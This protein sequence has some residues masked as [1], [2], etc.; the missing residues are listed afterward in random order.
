M[1]SRTKAIVTERS[2]DSTTKGPEWQ[3]PVGYLL[4]TFLHFVPL[5][6]T[7]SKFNCHR[8]ILS[9]PTKM[10]TFFVIRAQLEQGVWP[11]LLR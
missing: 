11:V 1:A 7:L 10:T 5:V 3:W 2:T 4:Q 6:A 8:P 9:S